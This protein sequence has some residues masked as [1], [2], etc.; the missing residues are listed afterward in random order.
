M[1]SSLTAVQFGVGPIGARIAQSALNRG[2]EFVGAV[3]V[4]P[5]KVGEDLGEVAGL[6]EE[7][8]VIVTDDADAA[9]S[10]DPD[11]VFHATVSSAEAARGQLET[12]L[13]AGANVVSTCEEL[14]YPWRD[15]AETAA[16]LDEVAREHGVTCLGTGINPGFAMDAMPVVL[17]T[18]MES[19]E[20]VR[21]ERVQD[22][23]TR[24][25]PLQRKVGA[26]TAVDRFEDEVAAEAGH[27][28][29]P[30]S[31][32]MLAAGLG[33]ECDEITETIEP[34]VADE[35]IETEF[36]T[37]EEG[38]VAGVHQVARGY[39]DGEEKLTLDLR[40]AV[41]LT[42][43][44]SVDFEGSPDVS[45]TVEGGYHG[46]VATSAVVANC[47]PRVV[48]AEAGLLT[49]LDLPLPSVVRE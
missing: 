5:E 19:V 9:L 44:D 10:A 49:M 2:V 37:V 38:E 40:M 28:G 27:V 39:V 18:P 17:S 21:V 36:L 12:I 34:V 35:T 41:G 29:S 46:D 4:D 42:S 30:E 22:A 47:A 26:G 1:D 25:E 20:S 13:E 45:I 32:A 33:W 6:G 24:R 23:G 11:V 14:V 16:A 15:H 3:D 31:T 43:R 7:T 8:G 48:E